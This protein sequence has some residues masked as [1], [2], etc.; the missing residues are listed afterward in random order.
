MLDLQVAYT[1]SG[2]RPT[3]G[4]GPRH[5]LRRQQLVPDAP[6]AGAAPRRDR[7]RPARLRRIAEAAAARAT[8]WRQQW[9]DS[10]SSRRST[11]TVRTWS[12]DWLGGAIALEL[13]TRGM[14]PSVTA[15]APA[16][17]LDE[18]W[19]DAGAD[20]VARRRARLCAGAQPRAARVAADPPGGR[21]GADAVY[22][23]PERQDADAFLGDARRSR[24]PWGSARRRRSGART[25]ARPCPWSPRRSPRAPAT[26]C[27]HRAGGPRRRRC[28]DATHVALRRCGRLPML[29]D[30][31]L[32]TGVIL[33]AAP[34]PTP[35]P[36]ELPREFSQGPRENITVRVWP[37]VSGDVF[38]AEPG[39]AAGRLHGV[40][41]CGSGGGSRGCGPRADRRAAG[42]RRPSS[43]TTPSCRKQ[44]R[45]ATSRAKISSWVAISIVM[46]SARRLRDH[47]Q[48]LGDQLWVESRGHLVQ[49]QQPRGGGGRA[50]TSATRCC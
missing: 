29:N 47:V 15:L 33:A 26:R 17:V 20:A 6:R 48:H 22:V 28:P 2:A 43:C 35:P 36:P 39:K 5:R 16:G 40:S 34:R 9:T 3:G 19:S 11:S 23:H 21:D 38:P 18:R 31:R 37:H 30:P 14:V 25:R 10:R 50:R 32:V 27:S 44:T 45:S 4:A 1:Q 42:G 24:P 46:P 12:A 49:Q 13:S 41:R 7:A 8:T